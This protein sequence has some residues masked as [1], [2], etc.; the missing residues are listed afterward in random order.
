MPDPEVVLRPA[1]QADIPFIVFA[2]HAMFE[3]MF[4]LENRPFDPAE[5]ALMDAI[6]QQRLLATLGSDELPAWVIEAGGKPAACALI[7]VLQLL[8]APGR[9][10]MRQPNLQNVYVLP[11]YRKRG[12]ARRL[13]EASII[14]CREQ[15][16]SSLS[17][18]ASQAGKP[19][20]ESLG[21][22]MG[23][24]MRLKIE[25]QS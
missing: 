12:F 24:Q 14:W 19:L 2:R 11:E 6:F 4:T 3:E 15:G 21:F 22:K 10:D 23:N 20:Y 16:Y 1:A 9:L 8:P 17:L 7:F 13:V 5:L 18:N 25:A